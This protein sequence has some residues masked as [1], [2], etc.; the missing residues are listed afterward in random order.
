MQ[1]KLPDLNASI[2]RWRSQA[3]EAAKN[4]DYDMAVNSL[5]AINAL[6]PAGEAPDGSD[7]FKVEISTEK[8]M[9]IMKERRTIDCA[10]CKTENILS[11]VKQF[12][13]DLGWDEQII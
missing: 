12:D 1:A 11:N 7:G 8:Y 10:Y 6:M 13:L 2:V 9:D 5:A 4:G 3:I